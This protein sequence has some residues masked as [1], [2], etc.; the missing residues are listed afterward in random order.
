MKHNLSVHV[1]NYRGEPFTKPS[2]DNRSQV[3]M[4]LKDFLEQS[5]INADQ[6]EFGTVEQ[7]LSIHKLL[8]KIHEASPCADLSSEEVSLLKKLCGKS[9]TVVAFGPVHELLEN[10]APYHEPPR[11]V[12]GSK[13]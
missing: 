6:Q 13:E 5:C 3:P 9:F 4:Q 1:K 2:E 10:P 7:K 11:L 12:E 8:V